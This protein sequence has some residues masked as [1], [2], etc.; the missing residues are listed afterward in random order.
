MAHTNDWSAAYETTP[1]SGDAIREGDDRIRELK[2]DIR[3]RLTLE[4]AWKEDQTYDGMHAF[5]H[6][7]AKTTATLTEIETFIGAAGGNTITLD[8]TLLAGKPFF[9]MKT[10][11]SADPVTVDLDSGNWNDIDTAEHTF[12]PGSVADLV[13]ANRG[14]YVWGICDGTDFWIYGIRRSA[15]RIVTAATITIDEFD[16]VVLLDA[17]SNTVDATLPNANTVEGK[18]FYIKAINVDNTVTV[19]GTIDGDTDPTLA[20]NEAMIIASNG[21]EYKHLM[22]FELLDDEVTTAKILDANVT[23][24]KIAD[25]NVTQAKLANYDGGTAYSL[26]YDN[27]AET[28]SGAYTKVKEVTVA[29][30]GTINTYFSLKRT[31]VIGLAHGKIYK[32]S[33]AAGTE[34]STASGTY[35]FYSEGISV[36]PGDIVQ[37]YIG[38]SAGA[39]SAE[40]D[41]LQLRNGS[42]THEVFS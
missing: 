3:E 11:S 23:T 24:A 25:S 7:L 22:K 40:S 8:P 26:G 34:R 28:K 37:L 30:N 13:L 18:V 4:H 21:T 35:V 17:T 19:I 38:T 41:L 1:A 16:D 10:D 27:D 9:V 33:V 31:G 14:D 2:L 42:P 39:T 29:R 6:D 12:Y 5:V 36:V 20:L 32:N 15:L